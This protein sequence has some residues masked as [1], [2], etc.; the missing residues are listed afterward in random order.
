MGMPVISTWSNGWHGLDAFAEPW[1]LVLG[2]AVFFLA[3]L[4]GGMYFINNIDNEAINARCRRQLISDAVPF[5]LFFLAYVI[6]TLLKDGFAYA[7]SSCS[8]PDRC[9]MRVVWIG[10]EHIGFNI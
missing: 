9:G 4:L 2:M 10:K 5:L 1:N 6:R 8:V 3:R 7:I